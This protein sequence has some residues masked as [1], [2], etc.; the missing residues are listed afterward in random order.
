MPQRFLRPGIR[1]SEKWNKASFLAQSL[2]IGLMTLVDDYGRYDG[3]A[4]LIHGEVFSLR[5]DVDPQRSAAELQHLHDIGL[6][7]LYVVEGKEYLQITNWQEHARGTKSKFP[8]FPQESAAI[9]SE[10][11][12]NPTS[13]ALAI[14]TRS[15]SSI[16]DH[17]P[18]PSVD[19]RA[20]SS[21]PQGMEERI[22]VIHEWYTE[23]SGRESTLTDF[24]KRLWFEWFQ[25]GGTED[26]FKRV[27]K[28]K[29]ELTLTG[30]HPASLH[31]RNLLDP[32]KYPDALADAKNGTVRK[33][34]DG[35]LQSRSLVDQIG[36]EM[37][38]AAKKL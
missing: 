35:K 3:R 5:D 33:P 16:L 22:Q 2:Y 18:S 11:L 4:R 9:R 17:T 6:I 20:P 13:L 23:T 38:R 30:D 14:G 26:D 8:A 31:L 25:N 28:Y 32:N 29:N 34:R 24:T 10:P 27:W 21:A 15:S 37:I 19:A 1:T 36:E 12:R 7:T